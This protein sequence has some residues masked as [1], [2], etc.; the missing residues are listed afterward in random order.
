M[1]LA[2]GSSPGYRDSYEEIAKQW[3]KLADDMERSLNDRL[4]A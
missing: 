1:T 3:R 4:Q 2:E